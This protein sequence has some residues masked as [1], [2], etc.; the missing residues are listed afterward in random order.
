MSPIGTLNT[1]PPYAWSSGH[2]F[3][4]SGAPLASFAHKV[5]PRVQ[6]E[7]PAA[8]ASTPAL[9]F[10]PPASQ[11]LQQPFLFGTHNGLFLPP[12]M[13]LP[14]SNMAAAA[15]AYPHAGP[16]MGWYAPNATGCG[17][18]APPPSLHAPTQAE[19]EPAARGSAN[20]PHDKAKTVLSAPSKVKPAQP[21][22]ARAFTSVRTTLKRERDSS[23]E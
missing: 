18:M 16:P 22:A 2:G 21:H 4:Q 5:T 13:P 1:L 19:V 23:K 3:S 8:A 15:L 7:F 20:K 17:Y 6:G 10:N 11:V 12:L 14:M 9:M